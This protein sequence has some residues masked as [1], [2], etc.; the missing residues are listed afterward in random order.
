[1]LNEYIVSLLKDFV[2]F[3]E[4][5]ISIPKKNFGDISISTAF[6][7]AKINHTNPLVIAENIKEYILSKDNVHAI[8]EIKIVNGFTNIFFDDRFLID[9]LY[10]FTHYITD[11]RG[12]TVWIEHTSINPNKPLHVGQL[13]NSCI[14]D[15]LIHF[16]KSIGV[17][18]VRGLFYFDNTG[19]Q[20]ITLLYAIIINHENFDLE[21]KKDHIAGKIYTK[22]SKQLEENETLKDELKEFA[23]LAENQNHEYYRRLMDVT[24]LILLANIQT[25]RDFNISKFDIVVKE[26]DVYG[27]IDEVF[28]NLKSL[29]IIER[30]VDG[31]NAG[32]FVS[33]NL[34]DNDN[35]EIPDKIL[36]RSN[37]TY[38]YSAKDLV[39]RLLILHLTKFSFSFERGENN[40][41]SEYVTT[42]TDDPNKNIEKIDTYPSK[43][44]LVVGNEQSFPEKVLSAIIKKITDKRE[45]IHIGYDHVLISKEIMKELGFSIGDDTKKAYRM[46]G[47]KG[48][49][50][51]A[52]DILAKF[53]E[54]IANENIKNK[55]DVN[56]EMNKIIASNAIKYFMLSRSYSTPI[57]LDYKEVF[58]L[59][60]N[61]AMY[62]MY[63]YARSKNILNQYYDVNSDIKQKSNSSVKT[64]NQTNITPSEKVLILK[65]FEFNSILKNIEKTNELNLLTNYVFELC[66]E[67]SS[68]YQSERILGHERECIR[69]KILEEFSKVLEKIFNIFGM[70]YFDKI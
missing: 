65:I 45:M 30:E 49:V 29:G 34:Y 55:R 3:S 31:K 46:S 13:R 41:I 40:G 6:K 22:I 68:F 44:M 39:Y 11:K 32:C 5:D 20:V 50:I 69:I 28:D 33:K 53:T 21:G 57:C 56:A 26:S 54:Y 60:G 51:S 10:K 1:M 14:G 67:F 63:A 38:V 66:N 59:E 18:D 70:I 48:N 19:L 47:R 25:L 8:K 36:I 42:N 16:Y 4:E 23:K 43:F 9:K 52:D 27:F 7:V 64:D 58:S 61:S 35:K 2:G 15:S 12:N 24:N 37:N 62:L 17:N